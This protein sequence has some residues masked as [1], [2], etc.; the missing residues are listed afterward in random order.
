MTANEYRVL[1]GG[2]KH[3]LKLLKVMA[4][5]LCDYT[6]NHLLVHFKLNRKACKLYLNKAVISPAQKR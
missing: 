6:K 3:V 4:A 5:Q 1:S 2:D